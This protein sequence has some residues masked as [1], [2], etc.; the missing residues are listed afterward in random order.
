[1]KSAVKP[2]EFNNQFDLLPKGNYEAKVYSVGEWKSKENAS[3]K[4]YEFDASA[5][6]VKGPDGEDVSTI[7]RDVT[8][9]STQIVFEITS[10]MYIGTRVYHYL[11]LH[12]NQ[13][14]ALPSFLS[15]CGVTQMIT[16]DKVKAMCEGSL[17][18]ISVDTEIKPYKSIDKVT[19]ATTEEMREKNVVK[20]IRPV[21]L[22]V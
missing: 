10:G 16:P 6:K 4:V 8:T 11:N 3:L 12:P 5:R 1:M 9:Y 7:E 22:K 21:D 19:G 13:P 15:A 20:K 2:Q 18:T 17:V 14:W